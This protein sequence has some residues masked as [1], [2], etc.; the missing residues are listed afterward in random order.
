MPWLSEE[1][2]EKYRAALPPS[3]RV[4]KRLHFSP[5]PSWD[6]TEDQIIAEMIK[7]IV[8]SNP[9]GRHHRFEGERYV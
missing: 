8:G 3:E 9:T 7:G 6:G 1:G 4:L 2:L 5:G